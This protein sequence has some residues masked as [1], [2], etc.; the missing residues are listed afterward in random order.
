MLLSRCGRG[1][2]GVTLTVVGKVCGNWWLS[3][4]LSDLPVLNQTGDV[5]VLLQPQPVLLSVT[6]LGALSG[7][8]TP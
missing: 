5:S 3:H 8:E 4:F 2:N 1:I 7:K 6:D